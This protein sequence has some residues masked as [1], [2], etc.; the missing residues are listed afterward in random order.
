VTDVTLC[1]PSALAA[2]LVH[3]ELADKV[4]SW[5]G[6]DVVALLTLA[7]DITSAVTAVVASKDA[8]AAIARRLVQHVSETDG[9]AAEVKISVSAPAGTT[10]LAEFNNDAGQARLEVRVESAMEN[11]VQAAEGTAGQYK[12]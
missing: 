5:R 7:A 1:L 9:D 11:A 10:I 6:A 12:G 3:E 2:E 4:V 8:F